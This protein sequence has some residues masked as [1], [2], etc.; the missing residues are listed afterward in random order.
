MFELLSDIMKTTSEAFKSKRVGINERMKQGLLPVLS[1]AYD[2]SSYFYQSN[3]LYA[4]SYVGLSEAVRYHTE[5][6]IYKD[7]SAMK[8]AWAILSRMVQEARTMSE[9]L[10]MRVQVAQRPGDDAATRLAELD[11]EK[12]DRATT[13]VEGTRAHPCYT[14]L[15]TLPFSTKISLS[16]RA[17]IEGKFQ[18]ATLGGHMLPVHLTPREHDSKTLQSLTAELVSQ[19]VLSFA[20]ANNYSYCRSCRNY[21][22]G[23]VSKCPGCE[24]ALI[25]HL[26]RCSAT[27]EPFVL[28]PEA[29][30]RT[31]EKR[32]CYPS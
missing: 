17:K 8:F 23:I 27:F 25:T 32:V 29:K 1:H 30:R 28:W 16:D 15:T 10:E 9:E 7:D 20:Y 22:V 14:D 2:S 4:I 3:G 12:Y 13:T 21:T 19:N 11:M 24:S 31:V 26:G 6:E 5:G 18:A